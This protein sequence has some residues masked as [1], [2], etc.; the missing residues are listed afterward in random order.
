MWCRRVFCINFVSRCRYVLYNHESCP[1]TS[2]STWRRCPIGCL[3]TCL[4]P[5]TCT[6]PVSS[7]CDLVNKPKFEWPTGHTREHQLLFSYRCFFNPSWNRSL[8]LPTGKFGGSQQRLMLRSAEK[9]LPYP[10]LSH[11]L[12][13]A[14]STPPGPLPPYCVQVIHFFVF[15]GSLISPTWFNINLEKFSIWNWNCF[16]F[17]GW[18]PIGACLGVHTHV[19]ILSYVPIIHT[20]LIRHTFLHTNTCKIQ[21]R[22]QR[23]IPRTEK[24]ASKIK[25]VPSVLLRLCL[26]LFF[27]I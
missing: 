11:L 10:P 25:M 15:N 7:N 14:C 18:N 19:L 13:F 8:W 5:K 21:K 20:Y 2:W 9:D 23:F 12:L 4:I 24:S 17:W 22:N 27:P 6:T 16:I 1:R 3:E 26:S